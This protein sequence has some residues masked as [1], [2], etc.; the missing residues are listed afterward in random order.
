MPLRDTSSICAFESPIVNRPQPGREDRAAADIAIGSPVAS[1]KLANVSMPIRCAR[2]TDPKCRSLPQES[3]R[4]ERTIEKTAI[5][6]L[7]IGGRRRSVRRSFLD[8]ADYAKSKV[9][10]CGSHNDCCRRIQ[11]RDTDFKAH[12]RSKPK[13]SCPN[14]YAPRT[15]TVN[16]SRVD[17]RSP[18]ARA[19]RSA[20]RFRLQD[21][22]SY[23]LQVPMTQEGVLGI[24]LLNSWEAIVHDGS[25][26]IGRSFF[27]A[28]G[29]TRPRRAGTGH[30]QHR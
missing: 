5:A 20:R 28:R 8:G 10:A 3:D 9:F 22:G 12:V 26:F 6:A 30:G 17:R 15:Y 14:T 1:P 2:P 7:C 19:Q 16:G 29:S 23:I 13:A 18:H 25:P 4:R 21:R 24:S 11:R 27:C